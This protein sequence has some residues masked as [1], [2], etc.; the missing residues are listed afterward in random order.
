[1]LGWLSTTQTAPGRPKGSPSRTASVI[2]CLGYLAT[3]AFI[4]AVIAM[5]GLQLISAFAF[6]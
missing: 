4:S 3:M 5:V 6:K 1:M 2:K